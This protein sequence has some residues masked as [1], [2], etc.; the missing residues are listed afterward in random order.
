[1][2]IVRLSSIIY[3]CESIFLIF[4]GFFLFTMEFADLDIDLV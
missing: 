2:L 3:P 1:M 4:A